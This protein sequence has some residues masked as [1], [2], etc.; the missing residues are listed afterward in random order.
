MVAFGGIDRIISGANYHY[1][2]QRRRIRV[3]DI[4]V[5]ECGSHQNQVNLEGF[6]KCY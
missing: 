1:S 5:M 3:R 6:K 2:L 4:R